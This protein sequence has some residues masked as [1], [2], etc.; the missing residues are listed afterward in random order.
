MS[1]ITAL[2]YSHAEP[3]GNVG[4]YCRRKLRECLGD[5]IRL[6]SVVDPWTMNGIAHQSSINSTTIGRIPKGTGHQDITNR[7]LEGLADITTEYVALCEH[8]VIYPVNYFTDALAAAKRMSERWLY[9][10]SAVHLTSNGWRAHQNYPRSRLLSCLTAR[11]VDLAEFFTERAE[12]IERGERVK[13]AEPTIGGH[14]YWS[15][16]DVVIDIRHGGNLTGNRTGKHIDREG[17][18]PLQAVELWKDL[19]LES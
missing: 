15:N 17:L 5:D 10:G 18:R 1:H 7:I 6:V 13:V 16:S 4:P 19:G 14:G 3:P 11:R 12:S 9:Y 8:D 2:Y